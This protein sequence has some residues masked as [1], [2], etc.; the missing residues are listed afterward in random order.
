MGGV[1]SGA[2]HLVGG[3]QSGTQSLLGS[4]ENFKGC[5]A[6]PMMVSG[7]D[8][9]VGYNAS[10]DSQNACLNKGVEVWQNEMGTQ[11]LNAPR[12]YAGHQGGASY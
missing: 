12:G 9:I 11:G 10:Y 8:P 1:E 7:C 4:V 3:L 2:Q 5:S 6:K